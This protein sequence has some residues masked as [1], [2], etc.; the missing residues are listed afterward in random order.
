MTAYMTLMSL[1]ANGTGSAS[2]IDRAEPLFNIPNPELVPQSKTDDLRLPGDCRCVVGG[3]LYRGHC[4]NSEMRKRRARRHP[5]VAEDDDDSR[6]LVVYTD[7]A[8]G[9][10][11]SGRMRCR[12][13]GENGIE[14]NYRLRETRTSFRCWALH[15]SNGGHRPVTVLVDDPF[16]TNLGG[17]GGGGVHVLQ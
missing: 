12:C 10:S 4:M 1:E 2:A 6:D 9:S 16:H 5:T 14:D 13:G 17:R 15:R 3:L 8:G 7:A 11:A